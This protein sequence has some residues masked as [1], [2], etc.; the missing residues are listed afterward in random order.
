[1]DQIRYA[2]I[3]ALILYI[4]LPVET[5]VELSSL[6]DTPVGMAII[7]VAC[8]YALL[9]SGSPIIGLLTFVVA[10]ELIRRSKSST[11]SFQLGRYTPTQERRDQEMAVMTPNSI[12]AS[13]PKSLEE[14]MVDQMVP[15]TSSWDDDVMTY[16][17]KPSMAESHLTVAQ[18]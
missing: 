1:M 18:I 12:I 7:I 9:Y 17:Y 15:L 16:N 3:V 11:G 4:V 6:I 2:I 8:I 14:E 13:S 10:F 5:P